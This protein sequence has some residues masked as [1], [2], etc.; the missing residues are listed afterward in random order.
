MCIIGGSGDKEVKKRTGFAAKR[1]KD[2]LKNFKFK[3]RPGKPDER[4]VVGDDA[5]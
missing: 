2:P 4:P 5:E 1:G 3:P